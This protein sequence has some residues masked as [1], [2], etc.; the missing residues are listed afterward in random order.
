MG[1]VEICS[2]ERWG[3]LL[4]EEVKLRVKKVFAELEVMMAE[5]L[6]Q[7]KEVS[8]GKDGKN[9]EKEGGEGVGRDTLLSTGVVWAACD[10]LMEL[11]DLGVAGVAVKRAQE[12]REMLEDALKELKEWAESEEKDED[13]DEEDEF[14]ATED[15]IFDLHGS[16]PKDKPELKEMLDL[17]TK[18]LK[19]TS[20]LYQAVGKRRLK[21]VDAGVEGVPEPAAMEKLDRVLDVLREIPDQVDELAGAFYELDEDEARQRTEE[22]CQT[23]KRVI[24]LTKLDWKGGEDEFTI[25]ADKW[26][27]AIDRN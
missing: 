22:I 24:E 25:W 19:L 6:M 16:M 4:N 3:R 17:S 11:K 27:A 21:T 12:Y 14:A 13:E 1:G 9:G 8:P 26:L 20:T 15:D 2:A 7:V 5:V 10:S 18:R 23:G